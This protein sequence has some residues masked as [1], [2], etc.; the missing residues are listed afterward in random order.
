[1]KCGIYINWAL[2]INATHSRLLLP[3]EKENDYKEKEQNINENK[4]KTTNPK[5]NVLIYLMVYYA[6]IFKPI[7]MKQTE[8][9]LGYEMKKTNV[10]P[11]HV[12]RYRG[13]DAAV[14]VTWVPC[15]YL[16]K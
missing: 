2:F 16:P 15:P 4:G 1:M 12:S 3:R 11:M 14:V 10:Y 13:Y 5:M 8:F 6:N 9:S 7:L